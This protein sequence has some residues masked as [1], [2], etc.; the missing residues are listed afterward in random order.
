MRVYVIRRKHTF[1][2]YWRTALLLR[3]FEIS[4]AL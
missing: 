3:L 1:N 2:E 4:T